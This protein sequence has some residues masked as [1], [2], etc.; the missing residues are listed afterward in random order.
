MA[1]IAQK[2]QQAPPLRS[3][4]KANNSHQYYLTHKCIFGR[5]V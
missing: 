2:C 4:L 3:K 5:G 1:E